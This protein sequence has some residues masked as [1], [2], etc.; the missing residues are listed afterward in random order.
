MDAIVTDNLVEMSTL[1]SFVAVPVAS[2]RKMT[3]NGEIREKPMGV[4]CIDFEGTDPL[5]SDGV[6]LAAV[7]G[8]LLAM[9]LER[10]SVNE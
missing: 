10:L 5:R 6:K 1:R 8:V 7:F 2:F 3:G 9:D 4:L